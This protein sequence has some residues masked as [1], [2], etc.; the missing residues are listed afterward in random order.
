M[1]L[2]HNNSSYVQQLTQKL[3][4]LLILVQEVL[5]KPV[6]TDSG[7]HPASFDP[8]NTKYICFI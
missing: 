3:Y 7:T 2:Q 8:L 4:I 1:I 5:S 6:Q